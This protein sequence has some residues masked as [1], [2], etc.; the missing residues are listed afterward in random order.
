VRNRNVKKIPETIANNE[1]GKQLIQKTTEQKFF[2]S[3]IE[4][5]V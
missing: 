4:K 1:D 5:S 2:L 3:I